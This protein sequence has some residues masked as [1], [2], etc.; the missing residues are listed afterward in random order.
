[1]NRA[2]N[3]HE[4]PEFFVG[5]IPSPNLSTQQSDRTSM[6]FVVIAG[7]R[8]NDGTTTKIRDARLRSAIQS[9]MRVLPVPHAMMAETRSW[10]SNAGSRASN[11]SVWWGCGCFFGGMNAASASQASMARKSSGSI[12]SQ[13]EPRMQK[14]PGRSFSTD[15]SSAQLVNRTRLRMCGLSA[16][17]INVDSSRQVRA[18]R[19]E[20]NFT[21]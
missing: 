13:S 15:G 18:G 1:M 14:N 11:A 4:L 20:R 7:R 19:L 10:E 21:W 2:P 5:E 8:A 17:P 6:T 3:R 9:A 16:K 12:R